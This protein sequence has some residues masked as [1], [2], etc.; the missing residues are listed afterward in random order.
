MSTKG[1]T[2]TTDKDGQAAQA[3]ATEQAT[4]NAAQETGAAPTAAS[5]GEGGAKPKAAAS[6]AKAEGPALES[7]A[8]MADRHRVPA[9]QEAALCRF[10][11]WAEGKM[12]SDAEY[13]AALGKLNSR[14]LGGGRMG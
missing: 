3:E 8:A 6:E 12:V 5:A 2:T 4:E 11:G 1:K 10:M 9:W 14:R 7:L 13:Q